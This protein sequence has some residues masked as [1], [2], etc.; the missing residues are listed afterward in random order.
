M[1]CQTSPGFTGAGVASCVPSFCPGSVGEVA[2]R[3]AEATHST[4]STDL[5][6]DYYGDY[7]YSTDASGPATKA[8]CSA[9]GASCARLVAQNTPAIVALATPHVSCLFASA[10]VL[11]LPSPDTANLATQ[12]SHAAYDMAS[13]PCRVR[14]CHVQRRAQRGWKLPSRAW[15]HVIVDTCRHQTVQSR[16][17]GA[18]SSRCTHVAERAEHWPGGARLP[19]FA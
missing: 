10:F 18:C 5:E 13:K 17:P 3:C 16:L 19:L 12:T 8:Q 1:H 11:C 2:Q 15:H 9:A 7:D 14:A 6:S 4:D